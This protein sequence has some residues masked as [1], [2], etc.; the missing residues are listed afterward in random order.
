MSLPLRQEQ[1]GSISVHGCG[2]G[3]PVPLSPTL[4]LAGH[5][6]MGWVACPWWGSLSW[7][8]GPG[9]MGSLML[10]PGACGDSGLLVPGPAPCLPGVPPWGSPSSLGPGQSYPKAQGV[11]S[12]YPRPIKINVDLGIDRTDVQAP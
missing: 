5:L 7:Q 4:T 8:G 10:S 12:I 2:A 6:T 1:D 3:S 9:P 11:P